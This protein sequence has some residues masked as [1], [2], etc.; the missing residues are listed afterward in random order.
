MGCGP[1]LYAEHFHDYG[2]TY[3]GIDISPYQIEYAVKLTEMYSNISFLV[4]D[5]R[6]C[7]LPKTFDVV[8]L[9]YGLYSFYSPI[10]RQ[11][12]LQNVRN[13]IKDDGCVVVEVF[14]K[15]HYIRR[16]EESDWQYVDK[17]GF[18]SDKPYLELNAFHRYD[19]ENLILVR[20][21]IINDTADVWNSWIQMFDVHM[22][23]NEF[24]SAGFHRFEYFASC[25]GT[26]FYED[27][28]V[29]C[30]IAYL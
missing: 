15:F 18:W 29:I 3:E 10:E 2:F 28:E 30:M 11:A 4:G 7:K 8:L 19:R 16:K 24:K 12:I 9:L 25:M 6:D 26:P 17:Y 23:E 27:S 13:A 5:I 20:A 14:T 21:G 1:G 22:L